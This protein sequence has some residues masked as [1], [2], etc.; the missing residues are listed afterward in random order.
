MIPLI[1]L[2]RCCLWQQGA[3]QS[4]WLGSLPPPLNIDFILV[5]AK[6]CKKKKKKEFNVLRPSATRPVRWELRDFFMLFFFAL[7]RE[8]FSSST[9]SHA[10][11]PVHVGC[12][13]VVSL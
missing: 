13:T 6:D 5:F 9:S 7:V 3:D 12:Y 11:H 8:C 1:L 10:L 2:H 4:S